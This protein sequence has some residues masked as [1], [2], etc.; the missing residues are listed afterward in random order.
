[1]LSSGRVVRDVSYDSVLADEF[2]DSAVE[3][4]LELELELGGGDGEGAGSGR[5]WGTGLR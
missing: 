3:E 1:M 2:D 5:S 4:L